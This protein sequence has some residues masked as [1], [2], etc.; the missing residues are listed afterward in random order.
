MAGTGQMIV[1]P[2]FLIE[3]KPDFILIMNPIYQDEIQKE[4]NSMGL[5]PE[6]LTI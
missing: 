2:N 6:I 1:P 5:S 3:Y 4:F